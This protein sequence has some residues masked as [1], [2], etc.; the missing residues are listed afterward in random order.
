M[1]QPYTWHVQAVEDSQVWMMSSLEQ[2]NQIKKSYTHDIL[3]FL[4][5]IVPLNSVKSK[6]HTILSTVSLFIRGQLPKCNDV[7]YSGF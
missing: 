1:I 5:K 7:T 4:L 6:F 3:P 2:K